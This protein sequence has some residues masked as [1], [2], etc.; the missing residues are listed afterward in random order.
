MINAKISVSKKL[1]T[2][3][4]ANKLLHLFEDAW[5]RRCK[6]IRRAIGTSRRRWEHSQYWKVADE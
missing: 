1:N 4:S 2:P 3:D 5:E 6:G